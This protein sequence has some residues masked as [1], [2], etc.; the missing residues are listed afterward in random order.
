MPVYF[1]ATGQALYEVK[2]LDGNASEVYFGK[3]QADELAQRSAHSALASALALVGKLPAQLEPHFSVILKAVLLEASRS[4]FRLRLVPVHDFAARA[5]DAVLAGDSLQGAVYLAYVMVAVREHFRNTPHREWDP[6]LFVSA[7]MT[8]DS[9]AL[10]PV[11]EL[12]S[13]YLAVC[14]F[15]ERKKLSG[16]FLSCGPLS[17]THKVQR[18]VTALEVTTLDALVVELVADYAR[19]LAPQSSSSPVPSST[20]TQTA[21]AA[22]ARP[23]LVGKPALLAT[24]LLV[25]VALSALKPWQRFEHSPALGPST[26]AER[27]PTP[28]IPT[29]TIE[30]ASFPASLAAPS[31]AQPTL[32]AAQAAP[33]RAQERPKKFA[34]PALTE[35][36]APRPSA[37]PSGSALPVEP[38]NEPRAPV[39]ASATVGSA[40][41]A[42]AFRDLFPTRN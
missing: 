40:T 29:R 19:W 37:S 13:K 6:N 14:D 27:A 16:L 18:R 24:G 20:S 33:G 36:A 17:S 2:K 21:P 28:P 5:S 38:S 35:S 7:S 23:R 15:A 11:S 39:A 8:P 34:Q 1:P 9:S 32:P 26:A 30:K 42:P 3:I 41:S 12:D 22:A 25:V 4:P 31:L 10:A